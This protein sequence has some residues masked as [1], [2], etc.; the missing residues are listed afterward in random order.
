VRVLQ[1]NGYEVHFP[2]L[3]TCCGAAALH[4]GEDGLGRDL[5]RRNID[6]CAGQE[7]DAIISNAGGCGATL[8]EYGHLLTGDERYAERAKAFA[9]KVK[10]V[11]EFLAGNLRQP[12]HRELPVRTAY[13]DSCHLRHGQRVSHQPR[14]LLTAIPGLTLVELRQPDMCCGSAGIYNITQNEMAERVLSAK[15]ADIKN[16]QVDVIVIS[17]TGCHMQ[18]LY[19]AAQMGLPAKVMHVVELLDR[20]YGSDAARNEGGV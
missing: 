12:P 20:A 18:M 19:G 3:Q 6:A 7:F 11:S 2:R 5:A 15:M 17:N 13:V 10:D 14:A 9:A 16:A 8:K 4:T 1:R